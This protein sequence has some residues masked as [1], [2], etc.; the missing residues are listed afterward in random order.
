[1]PPAEPRPYSAP[2]GPFTIS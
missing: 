1:M 2:A